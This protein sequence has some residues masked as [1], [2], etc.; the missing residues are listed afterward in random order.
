M[1]KKT[2]SSLNNESILKAINET[3]EESDSLSQVLIVQELK[4]N[5]LRKPDVSELI[6]L[7]RMWK[8]DN[9]KRFAHSILKMIV[10]YYLK[11]NKC[12]SEIRN[13]L[14]S[15][16]AFSSTDMLIE[17]AKNDSDS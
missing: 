13:R 17:S 9:N 7:S 4:T 1:I 10:W 5:L 16:F 15:E 3:F 8:K 14:C 11:H 6:D 2:A 12:K